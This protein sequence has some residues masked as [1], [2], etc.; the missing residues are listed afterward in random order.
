[1]SPFFRKIIYQIILTS[2]DSQLTLNFLIL[3]KVLW[4]VDCG[5]N[6]TINLLSKN[7]TFSPECFSEGY[8]DRNKKFNEWTKVAES[9]QSK[10]AQVTV[11]CS[12]LQRTRNSSMR[13]HHERHIGIFFNSKRC[14]SLLLAQVNGKCPGSSHSLLKS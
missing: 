9:L 1:M 7:S 10:I 2:L 4:T 13:K 8:K 12:G 11:T 3:V 6:K 14:L 5:E